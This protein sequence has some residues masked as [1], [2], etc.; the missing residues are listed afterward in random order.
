MAERTTITELIQLAPEVTFGTSL[1]STRKLASLGIDLSPEFE[2]TR[3]RPMGYKVDTIVAP[4]REWASGD[5]SGYPTYNEI[6]VIFNSLLKK[7]APVTTTGISTWTWDWSPT[8]V[9]TIDSFTIEQGDPATRAH[10]VTGAV[11]TDFNM[12][13]SR[14]G[15]PDLGGTVMAQA[16]LDGITPTAALTA[17]IPIPILPGQID[18]L[19]DATYAGIGV[20]KLTRA[21]SAGVS[22]GGMW[23]NIWPLN[24]SLSSYAVNV[25]NAPDNTFEVVLEADATGNQWFTQMRAG[26][27]VWLEMRATGPTIAGGTP[28]TVHSLKVQFCGVIDGPPKFGD[29]GGVKTTTWPFRNVVDGTSGKAIR[30]VL[31]NG[32]ATL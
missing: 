13:F 32:V 4:L 22:I 17:P 31:I 1:A 9:E 6:M 12:G 7:V 27:Q 21:F 23:G 20:T 18:L 24:T 29:E 2:S 25:Q 30:I 28:A 3:I 14:T 5:I 26:A 16:F 10:K 15:D 8:S 11:V 19:A